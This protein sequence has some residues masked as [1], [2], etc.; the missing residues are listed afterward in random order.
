MEEQI[1]KPPGYFELQTINK[2]IAFE[3]PGG[4][5]FLYIDSWVKPEGTNQALKDRIQAFRIKVKRK[6]E[7]YASKRTEG[8]TR[9]VS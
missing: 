9:Q 7:Y 5:K 1:N 3:A 6:V 4:I 2:Q 8:A